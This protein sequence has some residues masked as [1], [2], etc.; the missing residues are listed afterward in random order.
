VDGTVTVPGDPVQL[1]VITAR[2]VLVGE[3]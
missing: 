1:E 2:P 3:N